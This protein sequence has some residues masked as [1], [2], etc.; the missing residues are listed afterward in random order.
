[1]KN[2]KVILIS[3]FAR[4][5]TN[6]LWNILQSHRDIVAP[7]YETGQM[8]K[9]SPLLRALK[10]RHMWK[11]LPFSSQVVDYNLYR[12]K[13]ESMTHPDN[14]FVSEGTPYSHE[15]MA[16]SA[17]CLKSVNNDI[18]LA[19]L[20]VDVYPDLF[21]IGLA[22]NGYSL[23]DGYIRRGQ[24]A[25]DAGRL[26]RRIAEQMGRVSTFVSHFKIVKFE[27]VLQ[28]PFEIARKLYEF[29]DVHPHELE[30]LRLKSKRVISKNGEHNVAF[31]EEHRKYWFSRDTIDDILDPDIDQK[32]SYRLSDKDRD[33]FHREAGSA[34]EFFG[35]E[36]HR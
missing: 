6:V 1:M 5:G 3:G 23:A 7:P 9:K 10:T 27:E 28:K 11:R 19:D 12:F 35:Y 15:E 34:L 2:E 33:E 29:V 14:R 21:F 17:L 20:L 22:R 13:M 36:P 24:S 25:G 30:K 18:R 8:F 4:G 31:G 26:Y 16:K 32:Q